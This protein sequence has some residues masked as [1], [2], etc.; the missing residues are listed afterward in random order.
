MGSSLA[1]CV[2]LP[3]EGEGVYV[4]RGGACVCVEGRCMCGG[5]EHVCV[6]GGEVHVWRGGACVCAWRGGVFVR[7]WI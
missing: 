3:G 2:S 6:R 7:V 5:E 1:S 4:R